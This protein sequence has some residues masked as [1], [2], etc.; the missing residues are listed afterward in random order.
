MTDNVTTTDEQ[1]LTPITKLTRDLKKASLTLGLDEVRF[2][3]DRYYEMQER[4]IASGNQVRALDESKEPN[5]VLTWFGE[6]ADSLEGQV[7]RALTGFVD[8][9]PAGR[10]LMSIYGI[11]PVLSAGYLAHVFVGEVKKRATK[12]NPNPGT[13]EVNTVGKLWRFAG[14]DP[15]V[16]WK[17]KERRPWNASLKRLAWLTGKSFEKFKNREDCFYGKLLLQRLEYETRKNEAG[18]YKVEAEKALARGVNWR[19]EIKD[20][21]EAGKLPPSHLNARARRWTTK[22]FLSHLFEVLWFYKF[23]GKAAPMPYA[24]THLNHVDYIPVPNDPREVQ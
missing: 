5:E 14:L 8:T 12:K 22:L 7:L 18:E 1:R 17:K 6:Q 19:K 3:V 23:D 20:V 16:T 2:L 24:F 11:G 4:R 9:Q 13:V 21:Y 10:W 15:T